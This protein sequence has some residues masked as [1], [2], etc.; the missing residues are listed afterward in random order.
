MGGLVQGSILTFS[1]INLLAF[2]TIRQASEPPR[3][4]QFELI[5]LLES[6]NEELVESQPLLIVTETWIRQLT[7]KSQIL[8]RYIGNLPIDGHDY[9]EPEDI[10]KVANEL[11]P[12]FRE[13]TIF[14]LAIIRADRRKEL[15]EMATP[16][17]RRQQS[18][19][20]SVVMEM[21]EEKPLEVIDPLPPIVSLIRAPENWPGVL[22]WDKTGES[23]FVPAREHSDLAN[24][25]SDLHFKRFDSVDEL[26]RN[27]LAE[28]L[29]D[30]LRKRKRSVTLVHLSD[31]HFGTKEATQNL[32]CLES[33]LH[34]L[35]KSKQID[36]V[37]ITGDLLD[38]PDKILLDQF[39]AFRS[40]LVELTGKDPIVIPGNHDQ[41][42]KHGAYVQK[43]D[44]VANLEWS[45]IVCDDELE[46]VFYCFDSSREVFGAYGGIDLADRARAENKVGQLAK[47][48]KALG[49]YLPIAV[50]HHH[51]YGYVKGMEN[52]IPRKSML[53]SLSLAFEQFFLYMKNAEEFVKWC[54]N[55]G[56]SLILHG[57]KHIQRHVTKQVSSTEYNITETRP[58]TAV[59]CG[60]SLGVGS[61]T[62]FLSYNTIRWDPVSTQW[63]VEFLANALDGKGFVSLK[64]LKAPSWKKYD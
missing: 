13:F 55:R 5:E 29:A 56:I 47:T 7:E 40:R 31:L 1:H 52:I 39:E 21:G 46:C 60:T 61:N 62:P 34:R 51:P 33:E 53:R 20:F 3:I 19:A 10:A 2:M 49:R 23:S 14:S 35:T 43:L 12:L 11:E 36:R 64:G 48:N 63:S 54:G 37:V 38:L 4:Q 41:R 30:E 59:G 42:E 28:Y 45:S 32:Q 25:Y 8:V 57:H 15:E 16:A 50:I 9:V 17:S 6:L 18:R 22:F 58:V 27:L 44:A 24:L 26:I